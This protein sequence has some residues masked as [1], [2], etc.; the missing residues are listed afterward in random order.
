[1]PL[2]T[3]VKTPLFEQ[4]QAAKAKLVDFSGYMLPVWYTSL[5][6][7][8]AAVRN[9]AGLF[10]ISHMGLL[11][12]SGDAVAAFVQTLFCNNLEKT[13][14]GK[15]VYG[16]FLNAEG[17]ILDDVM[18]GELSDG[19]LVVVNASNK[20]KIMRWIS[21][22]MTPGISMVDLNAT[23]G[24]L[25]IQGPQASALL[26]RVLGVDVSANP[27][28]S[29]RPFSALGGQGLALRT[30]YTGEDGF[31]LVFPSEL[32]PTLWKAC[33]DAG[34]KPC[35][36]ACRDT[37]RLEAGLPLYGQELREDMTPLM[38]RYP[39]VLDFSKDFIGRDAVYA[40]R[41]QA[42]SLVTVGLELQERLIAR[43]HYPI[44]EGGEVTSGTLSPTLD[45]SIAMALV[46]PAYQDLGSQVTVQIRDKQVIA[47][48][49]PVPFK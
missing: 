38:T 22:Q 29:V 26:D 3:P 13:A 28:F 6:D 30:G 1:M 19:F 35:G 14:G 34:I 47:R 44:L 17:C 46:P 20:H 4:H 36:L 9:S 27:R 16:M 7:E 11:H 37:L 40:K 45:K 18:V 12:L 48:V 42:Q 41:D 5:K 15:M 33:L 8:H 10:D 31:E 39:W 23:N 25:A 49:V 21:D 24:F 43:S 32:L 2:F